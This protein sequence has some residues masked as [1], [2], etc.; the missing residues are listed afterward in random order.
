[1]RGRSGGLAPARDK[2]TSDPGA[3]TQYQQDRKHGTLRLTLLPAAELAEG[4]CRHQLP[5]CDYEGMRAPGAPRVGTL[6]GTDPGAAGG[7]PQAAP[8]PCGTTEHMGVAQWQ[9]SGF[10]TR[11]PRVR[12]LPP[13]LVREDLATG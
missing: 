7:K 11:V 3:Q 6:R 9:S 8:L 13:V 12:F 5:A 4:A 2:V 10:Q 1:M